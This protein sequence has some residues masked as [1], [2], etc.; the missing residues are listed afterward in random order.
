MSK[1]DLYDDVVATLQ[2]A[3]FEPSKWSNAFALIDESVGIHGSTTAFG[4]GE[5]FD[6]VRLFF[7]WYYY[8]GIRQL[9]LE[10]RYLSDYYMRDERIP[11]LRRIPTNQ[12]VNIK[13]LYT[14]SELRN[15][16]AYNEA[17]AICRGQNSLHV[18]LAGPNNS[19][20]IWVLHDPS[21]REGWST[22]KLKLIRNLLPHFHHAVCVQHSLVGAGTLTST[23]TNLLDATGLGILYLD[24]RGRILDTNDHAKRV[25]R[26]GKSLYDRKK[27]LHAK[28]SQNNKKLQKILVQAIPARGSIG[29]GGTMI[30]NRWPKPPLLIQVHP[31]QAMHEEP[32]TWSVAALVLISDLPSRLDID[33]NVV[34]RTLNFTEMESRIAVMLAAGKTVP[35]IAVELERKE[36]TIRHH[37]KRMFVKRN[38]SRQAELIDLVRALA[39]APLK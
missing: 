15:S 1:L 33:V 32:R 35:A 26:D 13:D 34:A 6:D 30:F 8:G 10:Q 23:L 20:I 14:K 25:L 22:S 2:K 29:Y 24:G 3:V 38:L 12:I 28:G 4:I 31:V 36:S 9:E 7:F 37:I 11:R 5:S 18:R 39:G 27:L 16:P 21:D 17:M 19:R